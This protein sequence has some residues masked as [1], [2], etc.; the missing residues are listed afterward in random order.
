M[1]LERALN[2]SNG[3]PLWPKIFHRNINV[4]GIKHKIENFQINLFNDLNLAVDVKESVEGAKTT[5]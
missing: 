1:P 5:N 4:D 3:F 2:I